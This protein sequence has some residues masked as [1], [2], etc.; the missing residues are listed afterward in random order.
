MCCV[1]EGPAQACCLCSSTRLY[2]CSRCFPTHC[3]S[4]GEH[5]LAP[6][7]LP[8]AV[9]QADFGRYR[10]AAQAVLRTVKAEIQ[11]E[12]ERVEDD[13][14]LFLTEQIAVLTGACA[15]VQRLLTDSYD[16]IQSEIDTISREIG[17]C[18]G[19]FSEVTVSFVKNGV[20]TAGKRAVLDCRSELEKRVEVVQ[21]GAEHPPS[22]LKLIKSWDKCECVDCNLIKT[23]FIYDEKSPINTDD[24]SD[25]QALWDKMWT[26]SYCICGNSDGKPCDMCKTEEEKSAEITE[27]RERE[28]AIETVKQKL[29]RLVLREKGEKEGW[30]CGKC[31]EINREEEV[32]CGNCGFGR[33][34]T[35]KKMK[36]QGEKDIGESGSEE[37]SESSL[38]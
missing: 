32:G 3:N 6:L 14:K 34:R 25:P 36:T 10:D 28:T 9:T 13:C 15:S 29:K 19:S 20:H 35:V 18:A 22:L 38:T 23:G 21:R 1:C 16:R 31:G 37:K 17:L 11:E 2:L 24:P 12:R 8:G 4:T 27:K 7:Q 30:K 33:D 5:T 26:V